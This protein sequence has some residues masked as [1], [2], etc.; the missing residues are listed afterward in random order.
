MNFG[1]WDASIHENPEQLKR[2][3]SAQKADVTPDFVDR[4]NFTASFKGS[5]KQPY[6]TTLDSCTCID[7]VRRKLPC[8]HIYRLAFELGF[9]PVGFKSG[10]NKNTVSDDIFS[11]PV[12]T[13]EMLY[14]MC[15]LSIYHNQTLFTFPRTP[16]SELLLIKDFCIENVVSLSILES[17][18]VSVLKDILFSST[19]ENLPKKNSQKKTFISWILN[20][21]DL[22]LSAIDKSTIFLEFTEQTSQLKSTIHRRFYKKFIH[23]EIDYGGGITC[24]HIIKVFTQ[25]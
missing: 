12:E 19:L 6:V 3:S 5:G 8:K 25:E 15:Y 17:L 21:Q 10:R 22:A 14:D 20:N 13:Q 11:L 23:K 16:F 9:A 18:P 7:F 1:N 24:D 4:D 2:I